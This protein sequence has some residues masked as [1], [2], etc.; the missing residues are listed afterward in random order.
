MTAEGSARRAGG[1]PPAVA[2]SGISRLS[3]LLLEVD[4]LEQ[5][6]AFYQDFLG[7]QVGERGQLNDG[8]PYVSMDQGIGFVIRKGPVC[9]SFDHIAFRC[10]GGIEQV[11]TLLEAR[12]IAYEEPRRTRYGLS[13]YFLDPDG[14]R[15]ECHDS[16]GFGGDVAAA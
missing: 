5:S 16:T 10:P 13:I 11:R 7:L 12:G 1:E 2:P 15:I 14:Y 9:S 3:H 4:S 6:L 8:R